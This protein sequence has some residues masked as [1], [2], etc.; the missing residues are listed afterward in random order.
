MILSVGELNEQAKALL[1]STFS[2]VEVRGEVSKF[3]KHSSKHWYFTLVDEEQNSIDAVMFY[4]LNKNVAKIPEIGD[5]VIVGAT[6][7]LYAKTGRYQLN[8]KSMRADGEGE[9]ER[10]FRELKKKLEDE[11]L[12]ENKK[13]IP[14]F[15][16]RIAIITS[17]TSS[18]YEDLKKTASKRWQ[19]CKID[20]Y[21][22]LMQGNEAPS[23]IMAILSKIDLAGYDVIIIARGG[24]SKEDLRA[25][26]DE[27]LARA[28]AFAKT[29]IV[30]GVGHEDDWTI[31][32]FVSDHRSS[33]PTASI[34]DIL[35]HFETIMQD[36]DTKE[37]ALKSYILA[38]L[39]NNKNTLALLKERLNRH[40]P[41]S[42]IELFNQ[43][44]VARKESLKRDLELKFMKFS[45]L[46]KRKE[47]VLNEKK[48]QLDSVSNL[49]NVLKGGKI[50][51]ISMLSSGDSIELVSKT[52]V[53][54]AIIE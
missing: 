35:P 10:E 8:V 25:F 20:V 45:E 32:D 48:H 33:T 39:T 34:V 6:V 43:K 42:T 4:F 13:P 2:L 46:L 21:N 29:P 15:P 26:N 24:G 23:S 16:N 52:A 30:T 22:S 28:I 11:G 14:K 37:S 3:T 19:L 41:T 36:L 18:A 7:D 12:F 40:D 54:K 38:I 31:V 49:V 53:K 27:S 50:C 44:I 5:S 51:D 9:I 17:T 1:N 47:L